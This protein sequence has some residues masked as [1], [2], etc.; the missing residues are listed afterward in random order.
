MRREGLKV[1]IFGHPLRV[2]FRGQRTWGEKTYGHKLKVFPLPLAVEKAERGNRF[3]GDG[4]KGPRLNLGKC[5]GVKG[6]TS[7]EGFQRV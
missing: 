2:K 3:R 5:R 4:A 6:Q 1:E 7:E